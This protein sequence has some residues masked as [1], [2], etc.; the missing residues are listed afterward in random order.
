MLN[1][2]NQNFEQPIFDYWDCTEKY[3]GENHH[4]NSNPRHS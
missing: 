4:G 1:L 2:P 3:D